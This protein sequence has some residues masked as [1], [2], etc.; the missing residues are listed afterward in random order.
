MSFLHRIH[1]PALAARLS[2]TRE[3]LFFLARGSSPP[4][5]PDE[6]ATEAPPPSNPEEVRR[7]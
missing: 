1:P 2:E 4:P 5:T 3:R 7:G 6:P